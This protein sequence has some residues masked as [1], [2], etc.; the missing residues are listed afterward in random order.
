MRIFGF[1]KL[2]MILTSEK[3]FLNLGFQI[4]SLQFWKETQNDDS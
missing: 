1:V 2:A 4:V 3:G